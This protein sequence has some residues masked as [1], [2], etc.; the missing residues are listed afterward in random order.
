MSAGILNGGHFNGRSIIA[1]DKNASESI[2]IK[3]LVDASPDL[4]EITQPTTSR[5]GPSTSTSSPASCN[6]VSSWKTLVNI[7]H[8]L[9]G[10][11][12]CE[13]Q[14]QEEAH[15]SRAQGRSY[16][17]RPVM[18]SEYRIPASVT[19]DGEIFD[20]IYHAGDY[21]AYDQTL[22]YEPYSGHMPWDHEA[23]YAENPESQ[24]YFAEDPM[25]SSASAYLPTERRQIVVTG[26]PRKARADDVTAWIRKRMGH[27]A[28]L[29]TRI[30]GPAEHSRTAYV[31]LKSSAFLRTGVDAFSH[32]YQGQKIKAKLAKEGI[33]SADTEY[34][35]SKRSERSSKSHQ[36]KTRTSSTSTTPRTTPSGKLR[37]SGPDRS[38]TPR[39]KKADRSRSVGGVLIVDGSRGFNGIE[40][41]VGSKSGR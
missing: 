12:G 20:D 24:E 11:N 17:D 28:R 32:H 37:T 34:K 22:A 31:T 2:K 4:T 26:F 10:A 3:E 13:L 35:T 21:S 41:A 1:S 15:Y 19:S 18:V 25:Q 8:G 40:H 29:I 23:Q 5:Y 30:D 38:S 16:A 7:R 14:Q 9:C 6:Q 36:T 39:A 27:D 33:P